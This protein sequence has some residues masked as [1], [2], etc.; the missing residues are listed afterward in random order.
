[1]SDSSRF[2]RRTVLKGLGGVGATAAVGAG[3]LA[4]FAGSGVAVSKFE[5]TGDD[6]TFELNDGQVSAVVV[7]ANGTITWDGLDHNAEQA[8]VTLEAKN[9]DGEFV[10]AA[11]ET[12]PLDAKHRKS[13]S[14][15]FDY[16]PVDLTTLSGLGDAYFSV[17]GDGETQAREVTLRITVTVD[18]AGDMTAESSKTS[19]LNVEV[20]NEPKSAGGD[21]TADTYDAYAGTIYDKND[22]PTDQEAYLYIRYGEDT[23]IMDMDLRNYEPPISDGAPLNAAIGLDVDE[24]NVADYQF[25][26]LP[27][28]DEPDFGVKEGS[29]EGWSEWYEAGTRGY[30]LDA[31]HENGI[32]TFELDRSALEIASGDTYLT[33]F[34]ATAGGE[35]EY[36]AVSADPPA[37]WSAANDYTSSEHYIQ[38]KAE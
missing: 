30:V 34:L 4:A 14:E 28:L 7:D 38:V 29:V 5:V 15:A 19:T 23:I 18:T 9:K 11:S 26:W 35:E 36:V 17:D 6:S 16:A 31:T 2:D 32:V 22:E 20:L 13:G 3:G 21:A 10:E 25:G 12:L 33:G 37:F 24:D 1:M 27:G 8:T